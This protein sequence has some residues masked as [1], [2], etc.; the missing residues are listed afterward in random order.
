MVGCMSRADIEEIKQNQKDIV[1]ELQELRKTGGPGARPQ[2]PR[3]PQPGRPDP[4]AVYAFPVG[5]SPARGPKDAW[6]TIVGV[7]DFQ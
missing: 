6:V 5:D 4:A 3:G 2:P 1:K 7:S